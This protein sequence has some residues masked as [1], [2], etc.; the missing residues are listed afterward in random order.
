MEERPN[1]NSVCLSLKNAQTG[2]LFKKCF[3]A[4]NIKGIKK[5]TNSYENPR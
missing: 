4:K 1:Q 2:F 3:S 5:E